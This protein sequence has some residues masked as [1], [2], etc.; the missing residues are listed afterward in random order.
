MMAIN[1]ERK[2]VPYEECSFYFD[3]N[4]SDVL[5]EVK[6]LIKEYGP[7]AYIDGYTDP[8]SNS[9]RLSYYVFTKK[10]ENDKQYNQR[11]EQE[12]QME[13]YRE[14]RDAVEFKRLQAKFGV[15]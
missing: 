2:L 10:P 7:D 8:Y 3:C 1:R 12:E 5:T 6:R 11:I 13:K 14:D 9:D 4:L 15:K